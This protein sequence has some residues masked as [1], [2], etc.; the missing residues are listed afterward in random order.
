MDRRDLS[1]CE[2]ETLAGV[3][4]LL[5]PFDILSQ[6]L[7]SQYY[8]SLSKVLPSIVLLQDHLKEMDGNENND[9]LIMMNSALH[10]NLKDRFN[11]FYANT[12][13]TVA[14]YV[15]PR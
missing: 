7:S 8:P 5:K 14:T 3:T 12:A 1:D 10:F 15:D 11:E 2:W 13:H 4:I 9:G 6:Y